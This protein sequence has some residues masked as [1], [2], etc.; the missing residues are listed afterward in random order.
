[1]SMV[2]G[3]LPNAIND[4]PFHDLVLD[5]ALTVENPAELLDAHQLTR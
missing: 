4:D 2:P 3:W 5:L 1:M